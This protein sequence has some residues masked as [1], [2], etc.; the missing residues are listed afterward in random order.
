MPNLAPSESAIPAGTDWISSL[1]GAGATAGVRAVCMQTSR[2]PRGAEAS[3]AALLFASVSLGSTTA[4]GGCREQFDAHE[5]AP[6][7]RS[8]TFGSRMQ[9][10]GILLRRDQER[11]AHRRAQLLRKKHFASL[12]P[13][14]SGEL[15]ELQAED[16]RKLEAELRS[17]LAFAKQLL[18]R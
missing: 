15:G 16:L 18:G 17:D 3:L 7:Y 4:A 6:M 13:A 8:D 12:T 2:G 9:N 1:A 14:E 5:V 10:T 11:N